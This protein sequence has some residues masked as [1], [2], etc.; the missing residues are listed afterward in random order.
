M[1]ETDDGTG[2]VSDHDE[3]VP[4]PTDRWTWPVKDII[5][6]DGNLPYVLLTALILVDGPIFSLISWHLTPDGRI[7]ILENP[8]WWVLPPGWFLTV[9]SIRRIRRRH[10]SVVA[11]LPEPETEYGHDSAN[12]VV[13]WLLPE[14]PASPSEHR[15]PLTS[16]RIR[17]GLLLGGLAFHFGWLW[18][19]PGSGDYLLAVNGRLIGT[20]KLWVT[21]P[22]IYYPVGA[23]F[24][25]LC[26]GTLLITPLRIRQHGRI[27]FEDETGYGGLDA[28]GRLGVETTYRY[29]ILLA[30][31]VVFLTASAPNSPTQPAFLGF[32][33]LGTC[34]G[35]VLFT[36]FVLILHGF[37]KQAK[38][39][40]KANLAGTLTWSESADRPVD[41]SM[42]RL[43]S[44]SRHF[45]QVSATREYPV[46]SS[47]FQL[48]LLGVL[49]PTGSSFL[50]SFLMTALSP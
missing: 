34:V 35:L 26:I 33:L 6:A 44:A 2:S 17:F 49:L 47:V 18:F 28:M 41:E 10:R 4:N 12:A 24:A 7:P 32:I 45:L 50:S 21:I 29:F 23:E 9:W 11:D 19:V 25:S 14:N 15:D 43:V 22:F 40:A 16:D 37:M 46:D 48:Y 3:D 36:A 39:T 1:V 31:F 20:F 5:D 38:T 27:D 30:T 13:Q 42:A 8:A